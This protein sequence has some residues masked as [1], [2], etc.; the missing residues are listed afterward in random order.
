MHPGV[1]AD[2]HDLLAAGRF[3]AAEARIAAAFVRIERRRSRRCSG[4]CGRRAGPPT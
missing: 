4:A 2:I 3:L 1:M